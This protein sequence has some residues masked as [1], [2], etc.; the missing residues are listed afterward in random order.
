MVSVTTKYQ[1]TIPKEVREDLKIHSGDRVV[2]VKDKEG[3]WVVMPVKRLAEKIIESSKDIE[4]TIEES[5]EGF[6][7]GVTK[8]LRLLK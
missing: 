8:N 2:F 7:E 6:K 3:N 5:K 4:K 1:V